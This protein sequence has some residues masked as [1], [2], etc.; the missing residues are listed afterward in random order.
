MLVLVTFGLSAQKNS[1]DATIGYARF[2]NKKASGFSTGINYQRKIGK[3][4]SLGLELCYTFTERRGLL[5]DDLSKETFILRDFTYIPPLPNFGWSTSGFPGVRLSSTPDKYF[6]FNIGVNYLF[7]IWEKKKQTFSVGIGGLLTFNDEKEIVGVLKGD[8]SAVIGVNLKNT[9]IPIFQYDTYI[10][11]GFQP[12]L[13]YRYQL[14]EKMSVGL[15]NK[16]Y[17]YPI[18][19]R[20]IFTLAAFMGFE[21]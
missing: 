12:Q 4:Q 17:C 3:K 2:L 19:N 16:Y 20:Y 5:P 8:F 10:D 15:T 18:S 1:L 13:K 14:K 9:S 7:D 6:N 21:F 11:L